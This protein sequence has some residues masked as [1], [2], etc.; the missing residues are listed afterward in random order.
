MTSDCPHCSPSVMLDLLQ[1]QRVLEH[2]GAHILYDPEVVQSTGMPLCGLCLQPL[3]LCQFFLAK[4]KGVHSKPRINQKNQEV[5]LKVNYSYSVVAESTP[6]SPCSN[7]PIHCPVCPKS[8]PAI[9]KYFMKSDFKE[10]HRTLLTKHEHLWKISN[11][12]RA[13]IKKI[14]AKQG[15]VTAKHNKKSKASPLIIS[16][17]HCVQIPLMYHRFLWPSNM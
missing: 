11:F 14:W 7:V 9:W 5:V 16:E 3:P 12:E 4:G 13:E 10:K 1:G 15:K 6:S 8:G 17:K 2:I